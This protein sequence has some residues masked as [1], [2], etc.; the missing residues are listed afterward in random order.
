MPSFM[1]G[2]GVALVLV[3]LAMTLL[4]ALGFGLTLSSS[5]ARLSAANHDETIALLNASEAALDLAASELALVQLDDVLSGAL[6]SSRTD[7]VPGARV[8]APGLSIDLLTLTSQLSCGRITAC[9]DLQLAEVTAERPWGANNP[10][11]QLFLYQTLDAPPLPQSASAIYVVVWI[12]DDAR[13]DDGNPRADSAGGSE[14]GRYIVRAR[15]DAFGPRGGRRAIEAE[16]ARLCTE[17]PGGEE[18]LPGSRV[19]SW[20]AIS[21]MVP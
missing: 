16:L 10:R 7:G 19:Q 11:W 21:A 17:G 9:T 15:A 12:G 20:R 13:E 8:I 4:A 5:V 6:T 14:Q 1:D 2:R 3:L 18:C